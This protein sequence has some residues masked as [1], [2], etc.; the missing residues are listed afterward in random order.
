MWTE[1]YLKF[2]LK[3]S[4]IG[5]LILTKKMKI[6]YI[7]RILISELGYSRE[8][9]VRKRVERFLKDPNKFRRNLLTNIGSSNKKPIRCKFIRKDDSMV[10]LRFNVKI[11]VNNKNLLRGYYFFQ[12]NFKSL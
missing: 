1:Q 7:N 9:L 3:E 2:T 4:D 8:E 5:F 6:N 11:R 12:N 10:K